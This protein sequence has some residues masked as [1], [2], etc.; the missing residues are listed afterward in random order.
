MP[1]SLVY[2]KVS[3]I[4]FSLIFDEDA[5]A[6]ADFS[7][8]FPKIYFIGAFDES[9]MFHL[10][11]DDLFQIY[12]AVDEGFV[13]HEKIAKL[14]LGKLEDFAVLF[15]FFENFQTQ[16]FMVEDTGVGSFYVCVGRPV[17]HQYAAFCMILFYLLHNFIQYYYIIH[18][19]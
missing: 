17:L 7:F 10:L 13:V 4:D 12:F 1:R 16:E 5:L 9:N 11:I 8:D 18:P 19:P 2:F 15:L 3:F 6:V 14:C